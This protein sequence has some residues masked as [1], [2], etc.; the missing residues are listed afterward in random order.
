LKASLATHGQNHVLTPAPRGMKEINAW[1]GTTA[2]V[3]KTNKARYCGIS[4]QF[5]STI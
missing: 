5:P 1:N 3:Q 2:S 4:Q